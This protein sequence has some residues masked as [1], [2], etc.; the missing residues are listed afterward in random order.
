MNCKQ[1]RNSGENKEGKKKGGGGG[2]YR[3]K[4]QE[5][6]EK[7]RSCNAWNEFKVN[8]RTVTDAR[9][10]QVAS[11]NGYM[12]QWWKLRA[13]AQDKDREPDPASR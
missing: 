5:K 11:E 3:W 2:V 4:K 9:W 1:E 12:I 8:K 13:E 7:K 6:K 10:R